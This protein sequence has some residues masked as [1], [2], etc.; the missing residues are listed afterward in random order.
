MNKREIIAI[1]FIVTLLTSNILATKLIVL[2]PFILPAAVIIYPFCFMNGDILTE[3]WGFKYAKKVII[4]G[5]AANVFL[6]LMIY[7]GQI[8]PPA[9]S[10]PLQEAYLSIFAPVPRIV[11]GSLVAYLFGELTNSLALER[12]KDI[13][14]TKL[15]F[16]RT[17]GSSIIGQLFD[18]VIFISIAFA[19]TVPIN[20]LLQIMLGQYLF[21]VALEAI[22]GT[23]LVYLLIGWA[24]KGDHIDSTNSL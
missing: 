9:P 15:L 22:G 11:L 8:L 12:I 18:T 5:F 10:W 17:I 16:L 13:T 4:A 24:K 2:G 6:T 23:P 19:G 21:K 14:G 20:V 3:V 7:I 1:S